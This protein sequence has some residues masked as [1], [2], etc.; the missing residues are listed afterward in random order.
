MKQIASPGSMHE[1]GC[2]GLVH[3]D[4]PEGWDGEH[5]HPWLIHVNVWQ[6][7][8]QYCKVISLQLK[9]KKKGF[10]LALSIESYSSAFSF[11]LTFSVSVNLGGTVTCCGLEGVFLC[12]SIPVWTVCAV[13]GVRVELD[14]NAN[15]CLSS[16]C[17]ENCHLDNGHGWCWRSQR[18]CRV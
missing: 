8:P 5:I 6:N 9:K 1:T 12:G 16:G 17:A 18:L 4:D 11:Y 15:P 14:V 2:S 3:W 13:F 7:P 10:S